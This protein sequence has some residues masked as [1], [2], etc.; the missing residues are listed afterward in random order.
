MIY[1]IYILWIR[2]IFQKFDEVSIPV[3]FVKLLCP[4]SII[5]FNFFIA[6]FEGILNCYAEFAKFGDRLF[7]LDFWNST[8]FDEYSRKWNR[9]VHQF[10]K[11]YV[12]YCALEEI[13]LS[14]LKSYIFT[15]LF[16]AA[17]HELVFVIL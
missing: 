11:E 17:F 10:L 3:T 13:G 15:V 14:Q 8:N 7:Y 9:P 4:V 5:A 6:I 16:S 12:Y 1:E 2:P